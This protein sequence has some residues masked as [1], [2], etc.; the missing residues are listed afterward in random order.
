MKMARTTTVHEDSCRFIPQPRYNASYF[1]SFTEEAA[2][3]ERHDDDDKN[4]NNNSSSSKPSLPQRPHVNGSVILVRELPWQANRRN[5]QHYLHHQLLNHTNNQYRNVNPMNSNSN[6]TSTMVP[7]TSSKS[8]SLLALEVMDYSDSPSPTMT[9]D[10]APTPPT[11]PESISSDPLQELL[12][13]QQQQQQQ[14]LVHNHKEE[15]QGDVSSDHD[16]AITT[17]RSHMKVFDYDE[18]MALRAQALWNAIQESD[19]IPNTIDESL[20]NA[21]TTVVLEQQAGAPPLP[22]QHGNDYYDKEELTSAIMAVVSIWTNTHQ[23]KWILQAQEALKVRRGKDRRPASAAA[24]AAAMLD[25]PQRWELHMR[26]LRAWAKKGDGPRADTWLDRT[27]THNKQYLD[28]LAQDHM[29]TT[30]ETMTDC[31]N[32]VL[33][34]WT[35]HSHHHPNR[36]KRAWSLLEQ[37]QHRGQVNAMSY[38]ILLSAYARLANHHKDAILPQARALMKQYVD[39]VEPSSDGGPDIRVYTAMMEIESQVGDGPRAEV[40]L[41]RLLESADY[42]GSSEADGTQRERYKPARLHYHLVMQAWVNS[43]LKAFDKDNNNIKSPCN[44]HAVERVLALFQE[45]KQQAA[46]HAESAELL[47]PSSRT[48]T[49][50]IKAFCRHRPLNHNHNGGWAQQSHRLWEEMVQRFHQEGNVK[51]RPS[52]DASYALVWGWADLARGDMVE[53]IIAQLWQAQV[54]PRIHDYRAALQAWTRSNDAKAPERMER[55]LDEIWLY[56]EKGHDHLKPN[57]AM[58]S[59]AVEILTARNHRFAIQ[60]AQRILQAMWERSIKSGDDTLQ[61]TLSE[62]NRV[63]SAWARL[64]DGRAAEA[65]LH[66]MKKWNLEPDL[67]AYEATIAAWLASK[68]R[69]ARSRVNQLLNE[70]K[71][72]GLERTPKEHVTTT[73]KQPQKDT[74]NSATLVEQHQVASLRI[75]ITTPSQPLSEAQVE[76]SL[77]RNMIRTH[78]DLESYNNA[79]QKL[80]QSGNRDAVS[81]AKALLQEM[82]HRFQEGETGL[83]PNLATYHAVISAL[84]RRRKREE[85]NQADALFQEMQR[86]A[87]SGDSQLQPT[88]EVYATILNALSALGDAARC[89]AIIE[90]M[91]QDSCWDQ[92]CPAPD[93][94]LFNMI[95]AAWSR[96]KQS[97]AGERAEQV[98]RQMQTMCVS[99]Q[100][101]YM[102]VTP[103]K[104]SYTT[105]IQAWAVSCGSNSKE[106]LEKAEAVFQELQGIWESSGKEELRPDIVSYLSMA[107]VIGQCDHLDGHDK[108][109]RFRILLKQMKD[110]NLETDD[111]IMAIVNQWLKTHSE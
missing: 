107:T 106:A 2:A 11:R 8:L 30:T 81:I 33:Q 99:K 93:T 37:M 60:K 80:A 67:A 15:S 75:D 98:L 19:R 88:A 45:M 27:L 10:L 35:Q 78:Q 84:T 7:T 26:I 100:Y 50:L 71:K 20:S 57:Q 105:V 79:L 86:K 87:L 25:P 109:R 3:V 103:D 42:G 16:H 14:L 46:D 65:L 47:Q 66:Q 94:R 52:V 72:N 59:A 41:R 21:A 90:R 91:V 82:Q 74:G 62:H 13:L 104:V 85:V 63:L 32:L 48:Y 24:A 4:S 12:Q 49:H 9:G 55:I 22:T 43:K 1:S 95:I 53:S 97:D 101:Q 110:Q 34:A 111:R 92:D 38:S 39:N 89:Q 18:A 5:H 31:Y 40:L 36:L 6:N 51:L 102:N 83:K 17:T 23:P 28:H 96:S 69:V 68:D 76:V 29:T 54:T 108:T 64:G 73:Q 58:H 61:P 70:M 44:S 56:Y 77:P